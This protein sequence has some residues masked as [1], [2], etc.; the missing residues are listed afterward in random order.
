MII[1]SNI[2][3][4]E[5]MNKKLFA[6]LA[7]M[8]IIA[9]AGCQTV[10]QTDDVHPT[11]TSVPVNDK[12]QTL[13]PTATST[14]VPTATPE[15]TATSTPVPTP[16]P[17]PTATSTPTPEPTAT[18]TPTPEPTATPIPE[19]DASAFKWSEKEDGTV[20]I[21]E[22][23]GDRSVTQ[24]V[25]PA[26]IDAKDVTEIGAEAFWM[27]RKL[28]E[29]ILSDN[30]RVIGDQAFAF[31]INLK[32]VSFPKNLISIESYAFDQCGLKNIVIPNGTATIGRGAFGDC[33]YLNNVTIP[34]SVTS[35][36]GDAFGNQFGS[37]RTNITVEA[38]SYAEQWA[39]DNGYTVEYYIPEE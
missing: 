9:L 2:F 22:Y 29:I 35:I 38:G 4:E 37:T 25:I 36:V 13:E 6:T 7:T 34:A 8:A 27:C 32:T 14:V 39:K 1:F 18:S 16:T 20:C 15:A 24:I 21:D 5:I 3:K 11:A 31:C 33:I 26:Q 23:I 30:I 10:E 28:E 17:E 12:G 19:T